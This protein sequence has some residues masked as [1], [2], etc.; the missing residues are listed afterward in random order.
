M[1]T[2][3]QHR[4]IVSRLNSFPTKSTKQCGTLIN[5]YVK[6]SNLTGPMHFKF[7]TR[8]LAFL[9]H[10]YVF[11]TFIDIPTGEAEILLHSYFSI[12]LSPFQFYSYH[13]I[14]KLKRSGSLKEKFYLP[15]LQ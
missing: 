5:F 2:E 8:V 15:M 13:W 3:P 4:D 6:R 14:F 7:Y 12:L 10:N 11:T 9:T 1:L